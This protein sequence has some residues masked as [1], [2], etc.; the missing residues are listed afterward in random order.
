VTQPAQIALWI[1]SSNRRPTSPTSASPSDLDDGLFDPVLIEFPCRSHAPPADQAQTN[2][3]RASTAA[4]VAETWDE[5]HKW[6]RWAESREAFT[7]ESMEIRNR[8][9]RR[10]SSCVKAS[11]CLGFDAATGEAVIWC[12]FHDIDWQGRQCDSGLLGP[13][14][15]P[16][17][18]V[19]TETAN[20][21][22]R[23]AFGALGMRRI[24]SPTHEAMRQAAASLKNLASRSKASRDANILP[25]EKTADRFCYSRF[26]IAGLPDLDVKW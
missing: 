24:A 10:V 16:G 25:G 6:M 23:Y 18:G 11:S 13:Q 19:R 21:L 3:R 14:E 20:A 7:A 17:P 15:R 9:V 4:A 1:G 22:V 12:G 8:H 2:W 26:D 5:L